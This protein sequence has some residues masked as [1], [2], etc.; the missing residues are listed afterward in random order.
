[1]YLKSNPTMIM[2]SVIYYSCFR[3]LVVQQSMI[4]CFLKNLFDSIP[5]FFHTASFV[6]I[7]WSA[8]IIKYI[9]KLTFEKSYGL[10]PRNS[11]ILLRTQV[12]CLAERTDWTQLSET[13]EQIK[14]RGSNIIQG[15]I[16]IIIAIMPD[17]FWHYLLLYSMH[18]YCKAQLSLDLIW[19]PTQQQHNFFTPS[20]LNLGTS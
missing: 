12:V 17:L 7:C 9:K 10:Y 15:W 8:I 11:D 1:M 16:I 2:C 4:N 18:L 3:K 20:Q 14:Y 13:I 19:N 6:R 5:S